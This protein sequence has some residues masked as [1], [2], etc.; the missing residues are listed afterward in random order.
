MDGLRHQL[1]WVLREGGPPGGV[2][3]H[4][5]SGPNRHVSRV[6]LIVRQQTKAPTRRSSPICAVMGKGVRW[7]RWGIARSFGY[8]EG[9][10][11]GTKNPL[12]PPLRPWGFLGTD[13]PDQ[14]RRPLPVS[15]CVSGVV[16][17]PERPARGRAP[18][19]QGRRWLAM[20]VWGVNG[21]TRSTDPRGHVRRQPTTTPS[22]D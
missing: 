15:W 3:N 20:P 22:T 6:T 9:A 21:L 2:G 11:H 19:R 17:A 4:S 16:R 7:V 13:Q 8:Q 5:S 12:C 10:P 14:T 1:L 18:H